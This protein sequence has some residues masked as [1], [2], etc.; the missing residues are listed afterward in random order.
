LGFA[1]WHRPLLSI[2]FDI[3]YAIG[4]ASVVT[5]S[6]VQE[7]SFDYARALLR[8]LDRRTDTA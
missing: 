1:D 8:S 2:A 6:F 3:V 7:A 5:M 4:F